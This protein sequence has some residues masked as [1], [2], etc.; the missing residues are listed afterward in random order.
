MNRTT[1]PGR[2]WFNWPGRGCGPNHRVAA[3]C[4]SA[5]RPYDVAILGAGVIGC[6]L[7][8]ELSQYQLQIV[9]IDRR[10]M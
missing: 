10:L 3:D 2:V 7:A 4:F 9:M 1:Q 6:A 5:H 8:Y